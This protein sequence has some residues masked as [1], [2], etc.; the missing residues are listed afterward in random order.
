[1]RLDGHPGPGVGL[2]QPPRALTLVMGPAVG[3]S[4]SRTA[5]GGWIPRGL[6]GVFPQK[7]SSG[8]SLFP[9]WSLYTGR[10]VTQPIPLLLWG[11]DSS[12]TADDAHHMGLPQ[13][14]G[15]T[16]HHY[17]LW[18]GQGR[19]EPVQH[20]PVAFRRALTRRTLKFLPG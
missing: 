7:G 10:V 15:Q 12:E 14:P 9:G 17:S 18:A 5:G 11:L 20:A 3:H 16:L 6:A 13:G 8:T 4:Q 1:M 2:E 19:A